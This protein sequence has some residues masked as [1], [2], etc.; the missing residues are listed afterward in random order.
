MAKFIE[1]P[2]YE[3]PYRKYCPVE[4][5]YINVDYI[6]RVYHSNN[7]EYDSDAFIET[8]RQFNVNEPLRIALNYDEVVK[9]INS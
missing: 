2:V 8:T 5:Q 7:Y 3:H 4:K 6:I 1:L 9:I